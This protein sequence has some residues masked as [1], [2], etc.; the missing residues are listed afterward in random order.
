MR[1][2]KIRLHLEADEVVVALD[3]AAPQVQLLEGAVAVAEPTAVLT[4]PAMAEM[5]WNDGEAVME[6]QRP[7]AFSWVAVATAPAFL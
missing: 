3:V 4:L 2:S 1:P 7:A 6:D 5:D